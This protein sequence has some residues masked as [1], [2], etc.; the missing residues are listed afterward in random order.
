VRRP[1]LPPVHTAPTPSPRRAQ[2]A[3]GAAWVMFVK[4][5]PK[6]VKGG[7]HG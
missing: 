6:L 4:V 2:S 5:N 7:D 3:P 1:W